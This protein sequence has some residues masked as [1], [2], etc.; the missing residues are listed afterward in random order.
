MT[1]YVPCGCSEC[2]EIAIGEPGTLCWECEEAGCTDECEVFNSVSEEIE[3]GGCD[4]PQSICDCC[5]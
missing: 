1:G 2:M 3:C 4:M 5:A